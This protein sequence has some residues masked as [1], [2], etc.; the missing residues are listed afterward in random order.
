VPEARSYTEDVKHKRKN[1]FYYVGHYETYASLGFNTSLIPA[2]ERDENHARSL[3]SEVEDRQ[4]SCMKRAQDPT[5]IF[6]GYTKLSG[7]K[8]EPQIPGELEQTI[9]HMPREPEAVELFKKLT[10]PIPCSKVRTR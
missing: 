10:G 1:G 8:G 7:L 4:R 2:A 5:Q 6:K 3:E 9:K